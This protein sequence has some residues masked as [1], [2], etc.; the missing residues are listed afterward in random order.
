LITPMFSS[1]ERKLP[2][3]ENFRFFNSKIFTKL[4]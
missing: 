3:L 4:L 1:G 2:S